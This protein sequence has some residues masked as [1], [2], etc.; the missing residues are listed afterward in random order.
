M[1]VGGK[2]PECPVEIA[3]SSSGGGKWPAVASN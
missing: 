1:G 2:V 3:D